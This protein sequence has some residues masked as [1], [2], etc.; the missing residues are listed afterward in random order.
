M[1]PPLLEVKRTA[2]W[3]TFPTD[4]M[5]TPAREKL[6]PS[7]LGMPHPLAHHR[8][9]TARRGPKAARR[10]PTIA[11]VVPREP[12]RCAERSPERPE[13]VCAGRQFAPGCVGPALGSARSVATV[14]ATGPPTASPAPRD[15][16]LRLNSL[17][18]L[19][20]IRP[21]TPGQSLNVGGNP[22]QDRSQS[23]HSLRRQGQPPEMFAGHPVAGP[24]FALGPKGR[25]AC[26]PSS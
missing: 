25:Y 24:C 4:V 23:A 20:L 16:H 26:D 8:N 15:A 12:A 10:R 11:V 2:V 22:L 18:L 14:G 17:L 9:Q 3:P 5:Q 7:A 13:T 19:P 6:A 21:P 1:P